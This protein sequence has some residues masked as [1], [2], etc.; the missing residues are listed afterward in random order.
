MMDHLLAGALCVVSLTRPFSRS[1]AL[2]PVES[3]YAGERPVH[4]AL[5]PSGNGRL[6]VLPWSSPLN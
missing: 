5:R 2:E 3:V 1:F 4:H 6:L